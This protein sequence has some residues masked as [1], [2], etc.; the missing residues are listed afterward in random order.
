M[1]VDLRPF[2]ECDL[3]RLASWARHIDADA[4]MSRTRPLDV[5]RVGHRAE[6]GLLWYVIRVDDRDVGTIW[7]ER[8]AESSRA[9]LGILHR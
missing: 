9:R 5:T 1:R 7:L 6:A 4:Y 8:E 2:E 3:P